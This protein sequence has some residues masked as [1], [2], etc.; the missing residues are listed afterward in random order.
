[1][2]ILFTMAIFSVIAACAAFWWIAQ[3]YRDDVDSAY[4]T[5]LASANE[6]AEA[7]SAFWEL[8]YDFPQFMVGSPEERQKILERQNSI[9]SY[10]EKD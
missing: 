10:I 5:R 1:M 4:L 9:Y 7:G 3:K 6:L 8:R 2:K